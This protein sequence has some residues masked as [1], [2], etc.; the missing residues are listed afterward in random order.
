MPQFIAAILI[1]IFAVAIII[2]LGA[3]YALPVMWLWNALLTGPTSIVGTPLP[4]LG[5]YQAWGL[6]ILCGLL[7]KGT[8]SSVTTKK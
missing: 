4:D 3:L 2:A 6:L 8:S 5:F 7:F 1:G